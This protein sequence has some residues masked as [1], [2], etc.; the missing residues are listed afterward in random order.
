[1]GLPLALFD[2]PASPAPSLSLGVCPAA[3]GS[4]HGCA[5]C[6]GVSLP[7]HDYLHAC[8]LGE[9][10]AAHL[11]SLVVL[12]PLVV[13]ASSSCIPLSFPGGG[14]THSTAAALQA[15]QPPAN[16]FC[17]WLRS[18][19]LLQAG[20]WVWWGTLGASVPAGK[21]LSGWFLCP[22]AMCVLYHLTTAVLRCWRRPSKSLRVTLTSHWSS[23]K[24]KMEPQQRYGKVWSLLSNLP[25]G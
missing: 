18:V 10:L 4:W 23:W 3:F 15:T 14:I 13:L 8:S 1:M 16:T 7:G 2:L 12:L 21:L 6:Q 9:A 25:C 5:L 19:K 22:Y 17:S 24:W 20:L 11:G